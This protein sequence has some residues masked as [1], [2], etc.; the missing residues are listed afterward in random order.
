MKHIS[1]NK[2]KLILL[3]TLFSISSIS[4]DP[5]R[6]KDRS[7]FTSSPTNVPENKPTRPQNR[8]SNLGSEKKLYSNKSA[9]FDFPNSLKFSDERLVENFECKEVIF[10][11]PDETALLGDKNNPIN[12]VVATLEFAH[13][14]VGGLGAVFNTSTPKL[15]E[16]AQ[17]KKLE[18]NIF[19]IAPLYNNGEGWPSK[20]QHVCSLEHVFNSTKVRSEILLSEIVHKDGLKIKVLFVKP[21]KELSKIFNLQTPNAV[22][23]TTADSDILNRLA[24]YSSASAGF[25]QGIQEEKHGKIHIFHGHSYGSSLANALLNGLKMPL[26]PQ[27]ISHIHNINHDQGKEFSNLQCG[28]MSPCNLMSYT[29]LNSDY[30]ITVSKTMVKQGLDPNPNMSFGLN[31]TYATLYNPDPKL[32]RVK[33]I[34]N[35]ITFGDWNPFDQKNLTIKNSEGKEFNFAFDKNSIFQS[36]KKI[37]EYLVS[38][39]IIANANKPLFMFVGR[40][41]AEKG[42]NMLP[43]AILTVK[44]NGGSFIIMGSAPP[45]LSRW[46]MDR[47]RLQ[48]L[49]DPDIH[50]MSG[51]YKT[52][53]LGPE[54]I[55]ML[56]RAASDFVLVPSHEE[57]FG[58][59]PIEGFA[60]GAIAI[61]SKVSGMNDYVREFDLKN[62]KG[63]SFNY[64]NY[65]DQAESEEKFLAQK[66]LMEEAI[67]HAFHYYSQTSENEKSSVSEKLIEEAKT[68][69]WLAPGG[70]SEEQFNV[71]KEVLSRIHLEMKSFNN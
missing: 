59:V 37:K 5:G 16:F 40:Y 64:E 24:Y 12:I 9:K 28:D 36:K 69:D 13:H 17:L 3:L 46:K 11:N 15:L 57:A 35:G 19:L 62:L 27:L 44:E 20:I 29:M 47:L 25:I 23:G 8:P 14:S 34:P 7:R 10:P 32:N 31:S 56:V 58:L 41:S 33:G 63:N 39:G 22:Y 54:K 18:A 49:H 55:G 65:T 48:Y 70:S 60:M 1:S 38:K 53:Q 21:D 68:F 30:V 4:C 45:T 50:I 67:I 66:E 2:T 52:E 6:K 51:N 26:R 61:T 42:I 71:Y 43:K